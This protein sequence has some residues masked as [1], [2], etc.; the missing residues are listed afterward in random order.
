MHLYCE[1]LLITQ[2]SFFGLVTC[3][4]S[5]SFL[6]TEVIIH[7]IG[8]VEHL[9]VIHGTKIARSVPPPQITHLMFVDDLLLFFCAN[10]KEGME[11]KALFDRYTK[12][13]SQLV[14]Y[15]MSAIFYTMNTHPE[16]I[17]SLRNIFQHKVMD[18]LVSILGFLSLL[19]DKKKVAFEDI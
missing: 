5:Y 16:V 6:A 11:I 9:G 15:S 2:W 13:F 8:R 3:P 10:G 18:P 7:L 14:N 1:I 19:R 12:W 17:A 4:R